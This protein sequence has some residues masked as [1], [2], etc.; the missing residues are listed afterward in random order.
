[1]NSG[2]NS[3]D[4]TPSTPKSDCAAPKWCY[5]GYEAQGCTVCRCPGKMSGS[6][7]QRFC[8]PP[9]GA[10]QMGVIM[11]DTPSYVSEKWIA[12]LDAQWSCVVPIANNG[13]IFHYPTCSMTL[14]LLS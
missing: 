8:H 4:P 12:Q 5:L 14:A 11:P 1:M 9:Y 6:T 3:A 2:E 10:A 13:T 7:V